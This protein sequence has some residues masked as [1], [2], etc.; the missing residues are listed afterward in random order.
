M[1]NILVLAGSSHRA[2]I[3]LAL[4]TH[5]G[6]QL[7]NVQ[8]TILDLNDFEMP[9]FSQ[10]LE[11]ASGIPQ[12]ARDFL[13]KI[14]ASD[15]IILSLAEH[16]GSYSAAF[17]N[18]FDWTT[19]IETK[20]WSSRPMLLMATSPGGRGGASVL[21]AAQATFP[22]LGAEIAA[23]FSLPSYF[24]NFTVEAGI[25]EATFKATLQSAIQTFQNALS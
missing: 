1:K 11:E 23:T 13:A 17:K 9:L 12:K 19:R 7:E 20:L 24:D 4:A 25:S 10:D 14:Q 6:Q 16:N 15:G 21:A 5:A 2:S 18:I 8:L 3:N 22:H